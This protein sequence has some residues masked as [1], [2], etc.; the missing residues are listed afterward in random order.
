MCL[1]IKETQFIKFCKSTGSTRKMNYKSDTEIVVH[2]AVSWFL[3]EDK[4]TWSKELA[5]KRT[6]K[7]TDCNKEKKCYQFCIKQWM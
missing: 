2:V 6:W 1:I 7:H 5:K 3:I 4:R